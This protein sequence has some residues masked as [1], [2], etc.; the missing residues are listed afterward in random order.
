M[1]EKVEEG[2]DFRLFFSYFSEVLAAKKAIKHFGLQFAE[3]DGGDTFLATK[4]DEMNS[5]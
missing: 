3:V 4:L 1:W 2:V 5:A